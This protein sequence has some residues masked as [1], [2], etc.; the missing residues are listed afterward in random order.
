MALALARAGA[1]VVLVQ[2]NTSNQETAELIRATGRKATIVVCDLADNKAVKGLIKHVT[3][4]PE[5]GGLGITL[6]IVV[7]CGFRA[8]G[9]PPLGWWLTSARLPFD[10][11]VESSAAR[12]PKTSQTRT[13]TR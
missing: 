2:R 3:G 11:A 8:M 10:Q 7:N 13:G 9:G 12:P 5:E 1:D 6:D 4:K